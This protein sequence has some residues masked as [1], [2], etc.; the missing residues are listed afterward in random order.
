MNSDQT[1]KFNILVVEDDPLNR[2]L[3]EGFLSESALPVSNVKS[4]ENLNDAL[5]LLDNDEFNVVLLDLN[6]PDSKELDTLDRVIK[7]HSY[8][9]VIVITGEY[10]EDLGLKAVTRGAQEYLIK[11]NFN[12]EILFKSIYYAFERK[13][14]EENTRLAYK[15]LEE[16]HK[17]HERMKTEFVMTIA[18]ELRT[19]MSI[20]K[21]I[22]SN[23]MEGV[24]GRISRKQRETLEIADNEINRLARIINDF[25]DL[26]KIETGKINFKPTR[27]VIQ[28]VVSNVVK[29]LTLLANDKAIKL[30]TLMPEEELFV[31]ADPDRLTQV[32]NNL[33]ENAIKFVPDCGGQIIVRVKDLDSEIEVNVED[34]GPGVASDE[35]DKIFDRFVQVNHQVGEGAHGTGLGLTI[36]KEMVEMH[37]GRI[38][39]ENTPTGGVNFCFVLPKCFTELSSKRESMCER[40]DTA[41]M[42]VDELSQSICETVPQNDENVIDWQ[43]LVSRGMDEEILKEVIPIFIADKK[44]RLNKLTEA[45]EAGDAQEVKLYAH[46]L[47]GGA[48]N[49]GAKKLSEAASEL[50]HKAL[51]DDLSNAGEL[52]ER[53]K[54]EFQRFE[55]FVSQPDWIEIAKSQSDNKEVKQSC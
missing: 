44:E 24:L 9:A 16:A 4:A 5:D 33:I 41:R 23:I 42:E 31:N 11:A 18:H 32:L 52:L 36:A 21:N 28:S 3:L 25:L 20:F 26:S 6:L 13:Q 29:F 53:I 8:L 15:E 39:A 49:L 14:A 38:W 47:E 17:E 34:N 43:E 27:I 7:K 46:A 22:I 50:E 40:I 2:T 19:P 48:G 30:E 54:T 51:Q 37:G 35:T 1:K 55:S 45:I 12:K 10:G